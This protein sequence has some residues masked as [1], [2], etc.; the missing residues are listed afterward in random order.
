M[1]VM[2]G[3]FVYMAVFGSTLGPVVWLYIPEIVEDKIVPIT[4]AFNW[5]CSSIVI[6]LVPILTSSSTSHE[7]ETNYSNMKVSILFFTFMAWC[8]VSFVFN[9]KYVIESQNKTFRDIQ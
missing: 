5:A 7:T 9:W 1:L 8:F 3:L 6:I 4:T 2:I